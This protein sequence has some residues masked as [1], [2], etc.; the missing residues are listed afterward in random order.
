MSICP[1][2]HTKYQPTDEEWRCP[3]CGATA[4]EGFI[5]YESINDMDTIECELL[6]PEDFLFCEKCNLE[7]SGKAFA[8]FVVKKNSLVICPT[9]KGKGMVN[10]DSSTA[11]AAEVE[12]LT[13]E[14]DAAVARAERAEGDAAHFCAGLCVHPRGVI[15]DEGGSACCPITGTRDAF[16]TDASKMGGERERRLVEALRHVCK[17]L[18]QW[19]DAC[20][21]GCIVS[22]ALAEMEQSHD[23]P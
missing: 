18:C 10:K 8:A 1:H 19:N 21:T 14:R 20:E 11:H 16:S 22:A 7:T 13:A 3:K 12:R 2:K 17:H 4:Q 9:C 23:H 5:I 15:G 6:H